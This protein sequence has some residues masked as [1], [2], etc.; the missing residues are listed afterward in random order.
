MKLSVNNRN[1]RVLEGKGGIK[2]YK[3]GEGTRTERLHNF[4]RYVLRPF[5]LTCYNI[6]RLI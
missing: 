4:R 5:M 1:Q 6:I 3:G 2:G